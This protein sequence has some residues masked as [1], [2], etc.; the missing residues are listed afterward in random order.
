[1]DLST[2][3]LGLKLT[4]PIVPS[5]SPLTR[6]VSTLRQMEDAGAGAVVLYSLF[7]EEIDRESYTLDRYL[8]EGAYSSA[9]ALSYFPEA[10]SY[11]AVGPGP[12]LEHIRQAKAA[13]DMPVIASLNGVSPGGWVRYARDIEQAGAD[14]LELNIYFL[15]TNP[16]LDGAAVQQIYID[17]LTAVRES[18]NIPIALKLNPYFSSMAH[19][20]RRLSEAGANGLVLFNRFYQPDLD[21]ENLEIVP[22]LVLSDRHE[23]RLPLRWA[24]ILYGVVQSDLAIT[25]GVHTAED[26]LK[27]VAAGANVAMMASA[28]LQHGPGHVKTVVEGMRAWL[29][30]HEYESLEQLHGSLSQINCGAPAAFERA[31]Y[32]RVVGSYDPRAMGY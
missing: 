9:E 29:I 25:T 1:M 10:P 2:T 31:N 28:L 15:A 20:A 5:S 3:W 22:N 11:R 6:H 19:M 17:T 8:N 14:A 4:S 16:N 24:A 30:D 27:A 32:V 26:A 21:L 23:L 13:L 12:Y 18:I 7:E